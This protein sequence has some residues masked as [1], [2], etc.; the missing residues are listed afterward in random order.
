M[1]LQFLIIDDFPLSVLSVGAK[2][3]GMILVEKDGY[4][5]QVVLRVITTLRTVHLWP[6]LQVRLPYAVILA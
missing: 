2:D 5:A 4:S 1:T 6:R 3:L